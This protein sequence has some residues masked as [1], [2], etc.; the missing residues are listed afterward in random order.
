MNMFSMLS[1]NAEL[2]NETQP[3]AKSSRP[4]SR[5]SSIDLGSGGAPEAQAA[6]MQRRK[7]NLLP[8]SVQKSDDKSEETPAASAAGSEDEGG[9]VAGSALSEEE[10]KK[11]IGEDIKEFFQI[12]DLGEAEVYFT[13]LPVEHRHRLVD[14]LVM[15]ALEKKDADAELVA[16]LFSRA[17]SRN[18][19]SPATF[20][21]GFTPTVEI[22]DDVAIDVPKAYP[23]F[24]TMA[25]GAGL[26]KDEERYTRLASKS[27]DS[28]KLLSMHQENYKVSCVS[29]AR[30][31]RHPRP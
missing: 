17:A 6:P 4:P 12:R 3:L 18:L 5:K 26:D 22:L 11:Q 25:K 10:A 21:E 13:K 7:L 9:E 15:S 1:Q 27:S 20:E 2:A 24:V 14:Q 28:D 23:L 31:P 30:H 29:W 8:R 19:C 16:N